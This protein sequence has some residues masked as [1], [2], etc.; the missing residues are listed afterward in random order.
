[1]SVHEGSPIHRDEAFRGW[2]SIPE[3]AVR[4]DGVV[5][6]AP[7]FDHNLGLTHGVEDLTVEQF[8]PKPS[9]AV[10]QT[11]V[12]QSVIWIERGYLCADGQNQ[13]Q[14][15]SHGIV[16]QFTTIWGKG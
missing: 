5:V 13:R 1:M 6:H 10:I 15:A 14:R 8:V 3:G 7:L 2:G 9:F 16:S 12:L 11:A 4:A